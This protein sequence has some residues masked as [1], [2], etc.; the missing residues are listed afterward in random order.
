MIN[1]VPSFFTTVPWIL[2]TKATSI[3]GQRLVQEEYPLLI[4]QLDTLI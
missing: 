3:S 1:I 4:K 2:Q